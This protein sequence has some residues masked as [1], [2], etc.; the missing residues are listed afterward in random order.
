MAFNWNSL[1]ADFLTLAPTVVADVE[2]S[3]ANAS[4]E[5][6]TQ[7]AADALVQ[8]SA[9][10]QSLDPNDAATVNGVAAVASGIVSAL[11]TPSPVPATAAMGKAS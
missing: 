2:T 9:V 11:K 6:K 1:V 3:H 8:A 4:A 7:M 10:A 5:T